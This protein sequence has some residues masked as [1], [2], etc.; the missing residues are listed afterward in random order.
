MRGA[1]CGLALML[2][3]AP[4][5]AEQA[6]GPLR[7]PDTALEPIA[8]SD[9]DGWAADDHAAAFATFRTS[10]APL[11]RRAR[12][13][14]DERPFATALEHVCARAAALKNVDAAKARAFFEDNF[15]PVRI[16]RLGETQ[17]F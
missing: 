3:A 12:T 1:A 6:S 13:A 17:G 10:C 14:P 15:R 8:F 5:F 9:L 11:I 16:A 7:L 4:V 2:L